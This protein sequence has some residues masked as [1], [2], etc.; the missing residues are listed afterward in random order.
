M[1][2][3]GVEPNVELA[4][5]AGLEVENGIR[6]D[7]SLRTSRKASTRQA[8]WRA[9]ITLPWTSG[10]ES[11]TKTTLIPWVAGRPRHGGGSR[12]L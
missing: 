10:S 2:G 8:T 12:F 9:F 5:A 1:A 4:Q 7:A 3:I 11:S 6:V